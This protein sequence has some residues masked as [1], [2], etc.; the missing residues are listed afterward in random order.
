[1]SKLIERVMSNYLKIERSRLKRLLQKEEK[2]DALEILGVDNWQGYDMQWDRD[3]IGFERLEKDEDWD[4]YIDEE[5]EQ[6]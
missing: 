4:Q 6:V 1:M 3:M 5:F 2:L